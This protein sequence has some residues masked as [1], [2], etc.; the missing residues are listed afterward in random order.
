MLLLPFIFILCL[1]DLFHVDQKAEFAGEASHP[2]SSTDQIEKNM[3]YPLW[4]AGES[5]AVDDTDQNGLHDSLL[6]KEILYPCAPLYDSGLNPDPVIGFSH[7]MNGMPGDHNPPCGIADL[8][9]LE[10]DTPPDFQLAV[11]FIS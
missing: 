6:C 8:E 4:L 11:S 3:E 2:Y 9:N 7:N 1:L 5:Q 10:L